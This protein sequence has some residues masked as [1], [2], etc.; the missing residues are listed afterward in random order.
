MKKHNF[1][2]LVL[3]LALS[4][5]N[6]FA[7]DDRASVTGTITDPSQAPI[8]DATIEISSKATGAHREVK[9]NQAGAYSIPGLLTLYDV[10]IHKT[11]CGRKS[12]RLFS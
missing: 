5:I 4:S 7:Q 11:A 6:L 3:M 8:V 9:S 10:R 12:L 2:A 1:I